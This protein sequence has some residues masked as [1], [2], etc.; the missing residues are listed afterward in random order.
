MCK[1]IERELVAN[2][3]HFES[4]AIYLTKDVEAAKELLQETVFRIWLN[5]STFQSGS[6]FQ[7][8]GRTIMTNL[9][10]SEYSTRSRRRKLLSSSGSL[11]YLY[12]HKG[13]DYNQGEWMIFTREIEECL[14][15]LD[16]K[17]RIPLQLQ[18]EG[19][20]YEEIKE[21]MG[22]PMNTLKSRIHNG[23]KKMNQLMRHAGQEV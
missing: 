6:N 11:N 17:Y 1:I 7:A 10:K 2:R 14:N 3:M 16:D 23:R 18:Y 21:K 9:F 8:W 5:K 12:H 4:H 15:K 19:Y 13:L 20:R 22:L